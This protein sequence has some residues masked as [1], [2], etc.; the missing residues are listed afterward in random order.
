MVVCAIT[1]LLCGSGVLKAFPVVPTAALSA[2]GFFVGLGEWINHPLQTAII[3]PTINRVGGVITGHP[4]N[5]KPL[6]VAFV[7]LGL[8]LIAFGLYRGFE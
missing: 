3:Q 6:G 5:N 7:L 2:G 4:R 8:A 1:F